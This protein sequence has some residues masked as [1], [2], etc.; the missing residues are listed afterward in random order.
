M[1]GRIADMPYDGV[2]KSI[3]IE[4]LSAVHDAMMERDARAAREAEGKETPE[5]VIAGSEN[6]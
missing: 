6:A 3:F 5:V 2:A 1:D 4:K